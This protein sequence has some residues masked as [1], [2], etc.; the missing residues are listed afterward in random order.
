MK[1]VVH[2]VNNQLVGIYTESEISTKKKRPTIIFL[3]S[4][5]LPHIGPYRFNV[6]LARKFAKL[7]YNC[8]RFDL[9]GIGDSEKHKDSRLYKLQHQVYCVDHC[10]QFLQRKLLNEKATPLTEH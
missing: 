1:E 10:I 9:S 2:V 5:L 8:F 7:G 3:N 4:G 6:K